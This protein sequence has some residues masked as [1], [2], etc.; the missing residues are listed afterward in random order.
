[1]EAYIAY[2]YTTHNSNDRLEEA[3][4]I[5]ANKYLREKTVHRNPSKYCS[6]PTTNQKKASA[7]SAKRNESR[8]NGN[9]A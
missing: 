3:L 4:H 6:Y 5:I 2:T 8:V 1:M 7:P 9:E